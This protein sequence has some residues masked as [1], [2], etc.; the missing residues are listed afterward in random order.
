MAFNWRRKLFWLYAKIV[1]DDGSPD[2]IARGW[3]IGMFIGCV[4]PMSLQ[5]IISIPLSFVLRGSKIGAAL[6]TFITNPFTVLVLYPA[7]CWVGNKIIGGDLTWKA[8][9]QAALGLIKLD[10]TGFFHLGWDLIA[11]FFIGGF[12]L[13]LV[14]TP[15][16]YFTVYRLV[17]RYRRIKEALRAKRNARKAAETEP[18]K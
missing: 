9:E 3:A 11:S 10:L 14:L 6:G 17:G 16:T 18:F 13:A 7:Q 5:L 1:R 2:Y 8:T 15:V 4:V 12:L